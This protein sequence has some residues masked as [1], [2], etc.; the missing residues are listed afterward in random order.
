[1]WQEAS[2]LLS[3]AVGMTLVY[4]GFERI[5]AG[6][7]AKREDGAPRRAAPL[8]KAALLGVAL[9]LLGALAVYSAVRQLHAP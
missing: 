2:I 9:A 7:R 5:F 3:F 1:M 6:R 8:M 4:A